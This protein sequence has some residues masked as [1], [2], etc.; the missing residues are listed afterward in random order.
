[1]N[2]KRKTSNSGAKN[3]S[4]NSK[5]RKKRYNDREE[6][7]DI[8]QGAKKTRVSSDNDW[9]WYAQNEQLLR[10][11]ASFSYN[12]PLGTTVTITPDSSDP[13]NTAAIPGVMAIY[14]SPAYGSSL[15]ANSPLNVAI[16]NIYSFVRH[17]NSGHTNYDAPD[18]GIYLMAMDNLYSY[19]S[20]LRRVYGVAMT[21]S[22]TNRY[23]PTAVMNAMGVDFEDIHQNLADF[24]AYI[25]SLSVKVGSMC[26]PASMS[27]FARHMWMYEGYYVDTDQDKAQTFLYT[28]AGFFKY[29]LNT[30]Q[31]GMLTYVPLI[32]PED[33][34]SSTDIA[35]T[36]LLKFKDL[37][38]YGDTLIETILRSEDMNIMSG[39]I[40]KAF[41]RENVY[42]IP[43]I[44]EN[45]VVLPSF[46]EEVVNQVNN[47]TLIGPRCFTGDGSFLETNSLEQDPTHGYLVEN[48]TCAI[49][50]PD[51][52]TSAAN[53][54]DRGALTSKKYLNFDHGDVSPADSMVASR[55]TNI[56]P[57]GQIDSDSG[58]HFGSTP[59]GS[60]YTG[61]VW[62]NSDMLPQDSTFGT[63]VA[64]FAS[65]FY[66]GSNGLVRSEMITAVLPVVITA[67]D[68]SQS[69][70]NALVRNVQFDTARIN[71]LTNFRRHPRVAYQY[72]ITIGSVSS[73]G[74][75]VANIGDLNYWTV[76]DVY[77]LKG[78]SETALLSEF[79]VTQYGRKA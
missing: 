35:D 18:L 41:G 62:S 63:D 71:M 8:G 66:Y 67:A 36:S 55:L 4:Q 65:I 57:S 79:N 20:F 15:V 78:M 9:R 6:A 37:H 49:T 40:L 17:A 74:Q 56:I 77:D 23:Y 46:N 21:F 42:M 52:T 3:C 48:I 29:N 31:S 58:I 70:I 28:P 22:Y 61:I 34:V 50:S 68:A 13:I 38:D 25:N 44:P 72:Y 43:M 5:Y 64:H 2:K 76:V 73:A 45:Y 39:D 47:A 60:G 16:R 27:V 32:N 33:Y 10:D 24:R 54:I 59:S 19:I 53:A 1:M 26:I 14:C 7:D 12:Y 69:G 75:Y 30:D 51:M 11:S